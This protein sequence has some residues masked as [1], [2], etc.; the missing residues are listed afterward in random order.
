MLMCLRKIKANFHPH[1]HHRDLCDA[2]N[3]FEWLHDSRWRGLLVFSLLKLV[4]IH[5]VWGQNSCIRDEFLS[6]EGLCCLS[7]IHLCTYCVIDL[8]LWLAVCCVVCNLVDVV[9][10]C[11]A[12][13]VLL[14]PFCP[15]DGPAKSRELWQ[16]VHTWASENDT[17]RQFGHH[18]LRRWCIQRLFLLQSLF[19]CLCQILSCVACMYGDSFFLFSVLFHSF[20]LHDLVD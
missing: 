8:H 4:W 5:M 19:W 12:T 9:D 14:C 7:W 10:L 17:H 13:V 6:R 11:D 2:V 3:V 16:V 20:Y 1:E 18:E 15:V